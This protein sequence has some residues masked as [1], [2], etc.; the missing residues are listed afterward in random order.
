MLTICRDYPTAYICQCQ[1]LYEAVLFVSLNDTYPS[2]IDSVHTYTM[3]Y[4]LQFL[5]PVGPSL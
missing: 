5:W 2:V 1:H 4:C 3:A